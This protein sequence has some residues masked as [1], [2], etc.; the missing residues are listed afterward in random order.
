MVLVEVGIVAYDGLFQF[1]DIIAR[2]IL[3]GFSNGGIV[4]GYPTTSIS[5]SAPRRVF[6]GRCSVDPSEALG[7]NQSSG[8]SG[9][10]ERDWHARV[11]NMN[12]VWRWHTHL[13]ARG[14]LW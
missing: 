6:D 12:G 2:T 10:W 7:Q 5:K 4:E 14:H 9:S 13:E 1:G 11:L 3:L 8:Q